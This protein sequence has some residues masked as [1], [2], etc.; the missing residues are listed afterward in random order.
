MRG[1]T[2]DGLL[3]AEYV[4]LMNDWLQLSVVKRVP[5]TLLVMANMLAMFAK[6]NTME[7]MLPSA[8]SM[9]SDDVIK[10][11]RH[12]EAVLNRLS[13]RLHLLAITWL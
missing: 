8:V 13:S 6:E 9:L 7:A 1:L 12:G 11:V 2:S 10:E 3:K 5:T 4:D